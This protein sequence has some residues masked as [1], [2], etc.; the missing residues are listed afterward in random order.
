[1]LTVTH[2]AVTVTGTTGAALAANAN[3]VYACFQNISDT[4][5]FIK[6]G[7]AAVASQGIQINSGGSSYEL[8][9]QTG[10]VYHGVVNV[11]HGGTGNKTLLVTEGV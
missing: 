8:S 3:R 1:M 7:A 5:M 6:L 9:R 11:I 2:T 4:D 10:N